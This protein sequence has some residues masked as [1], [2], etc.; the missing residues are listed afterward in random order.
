M[1]IHAIKHWPD[2]HDRGL[3]IHGS[4]PRMRVPSS[5]RLQAPLSTPGEIRAQIRVSVVAGGAPEPGKIR[6][7]GGDRVGCGLRGVLLIGTF[8]HVLCSPT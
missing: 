6:S 1:A 2:L 4:R 5:Q 8:D 7:H 3:K